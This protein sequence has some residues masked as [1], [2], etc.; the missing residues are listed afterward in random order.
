[1]VELS[2]F[3]PFDLLI[4][5]LLN[6]VVIAVGFWL[7][8]NSDQ[9]QKVLVAGFAAALAGAVAIWCAV[10]VGLVVAHG[11]GG[12]AGLFVISIVVGTFWAAVGRLTARRSSGE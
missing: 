2:P 7:G 11:V 5:A 9:W 1:M 10:L 3:R 12:E 6:P 8:R 4:L